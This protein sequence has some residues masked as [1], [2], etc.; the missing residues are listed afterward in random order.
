MRGKHWQEKSNCYV[1]GFLMEYTIN[2]I[3]RF[4]KY[5]KEALKEHYYTNQYLKIL[6]T[7]GEIQKL[8]EKRFSSA[9]IF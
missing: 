5:M 3:F 8:R 2:P 6:N 7:H 4:D 9:E 1:D